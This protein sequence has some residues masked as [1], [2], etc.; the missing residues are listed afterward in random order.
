MYVPF[1]DATF[2]PVSFGRRR[3]STATS[4]CRASMRSRRATPRGKLWLALTNLDPQPAGDA[5]TSMSPA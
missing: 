2:V 1:Q 5:S 4:S 3:T